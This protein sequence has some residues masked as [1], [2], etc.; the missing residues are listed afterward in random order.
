MVKILLC[1]IINVAFEEVIAGE[2]LRFQHQVLYFS[3]DVS[4]IVKVL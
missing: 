3:H 1:E 4:D 2:E